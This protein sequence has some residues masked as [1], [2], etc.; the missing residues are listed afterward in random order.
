MMFSSL[1]ATA[2]FLVSERRVDE[3]ILASLASMPVACIGSETSRSSIGTTGHR[4]RASMWFVR[5]R[6]IH[7]ISRH[8]G[9]I[10]GADIDGTGYHPIVEKP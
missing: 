8:Q 4:S 6:Q 1:E 7:E 5:D 3:M 10:G 2:R 9:E